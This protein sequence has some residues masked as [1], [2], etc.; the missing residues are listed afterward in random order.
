MI[1][2][3]DIKY[4]GVATGDFARPKRHPEDWKHFRYH[5]E[6]TLPSRYVKKRY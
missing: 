3:G 4:V 1:M 5:S 2:A 6:R